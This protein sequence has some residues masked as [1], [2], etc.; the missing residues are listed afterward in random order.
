MVLGHHLS[1]AAV[2]VPLPGTGATDYF[3]VTL[4]EQWGRGQ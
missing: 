4:W 2:M 3:Q 1:D